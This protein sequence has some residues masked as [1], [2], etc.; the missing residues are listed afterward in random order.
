MSQT[1]NRL[2]VVP[3]SVRLAMPALTVLFAL[4][5]PVAAAAQP[6]EG[7]ASA[8]DQ[9]RSF[10]GTGAVLPLR[11]RVEPT[12]RLLTH[13]LETL[14]P[15]LMAEADLDM[16]LVLN[17]E[18]AEDPV[19]FTLVPQPAFAA[20]RTTMLVFARREDGGIDRLTVNRYPLGEP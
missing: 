12:N 13:R 1:M 4:L 9:G 5:L 17:R 8:W 7:A 2:A 18:Y 10:A 6:V 16:W 14:L 11:E 19:Y 15:K 3:L 20:R